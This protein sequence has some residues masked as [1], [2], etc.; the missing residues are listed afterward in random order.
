MRARRFRTK[1][2][3]NKKQLRSLVDMEQSGNE[4]MPQLERCSRGGKISF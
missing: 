1:E 2:K 3:K 4:P